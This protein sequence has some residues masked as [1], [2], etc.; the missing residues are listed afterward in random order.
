M[1]LFLCRPEDKHPTRALCLSGGP[2]RRGLCTPPKNTCLTP[3][4]A[5]SVVK[6]GAYHCMSAR[7]SSPSSKFAPCISSCPFISSLPPSCSKSLRLVWRIL[8]SRRSTGPLVR[9]SWPSCLLRMGSTS[10]VQLA[11]E[12]VCLVGTKHAMD[13]EFL[14]VN[15]RLN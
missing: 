6:P 3:P 8:I 7:L 13:L 11:R 5:V 2:G 10:P 1:F 14:G 12:G 9:A 4:N 15:F